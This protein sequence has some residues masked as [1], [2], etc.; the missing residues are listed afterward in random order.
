MLLGNKCDLEERDVSDEAIEN[1]VSLN[2]LIYMET[3]ALN[4]HNIEEAFA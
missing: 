1:Y 3:S 2:K 4:G